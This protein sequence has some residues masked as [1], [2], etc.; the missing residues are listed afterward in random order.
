MYK[1]LMLNKPLQLL[2]NTTFRTNQSS[3]SYL[4]FYIKNVKVIN[5]QVSRN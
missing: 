2:F 3:N 5:K 4:P 1:S